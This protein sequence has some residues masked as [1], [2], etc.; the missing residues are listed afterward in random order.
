M[1]RRL[2]LV[3]LVAAAAGAAAYAALLPAD[4]GGAAQ[5]FT[6]RPAATV[7][8]IAAD[9]AAARLIRSA[10]AFDLAAR[11]RGLARRLQSGEYLL[12]PRMS[13]LEI[14]DHL[15]SGDVVLRR[16]TIPEG[17][18]IRQIADAFRL[19]G[20]AGAPGFERVAQREAAA[21]PFA[22]ARAIP[23]GSLEGYLF[24]DTYRVDH[25]ASARDLAA[26]M[27]RRFDAVLTP[28]RRRAAAARG[29]TVHAL[30]TVASLVE[31]EARV[32]DERPLVA[33]V[34]YNRLRRG[35]PLQI[36]ATVLYALGDH[37]DRLTYADL[38]VDSPYNTYRRPGL[39]PGP[40][41]SPG[42]ASLDAALH[43]AAADYLYYVLTPDGRHRFSRTYAEHLRAVR[44]YQTP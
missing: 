42:L 1:R 20:V 23:T 38:A 30:V 6:V 33:A 16:V 34:I 2:L 27:L 7:Q 37:R 4:P 41:A 5:V 24:P 15:A 11:A 9:L 22:F 17:W 40:I 3:A 12:T 10:L 29:L 19:A 36:D 35:M 26:M 39:P 18:T 31:R 44:R 32:P 43:P 13:A 25:A 8:S 28:E 14:L 21:F